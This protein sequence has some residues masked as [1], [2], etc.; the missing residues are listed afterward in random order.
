MRV[1]ARSGYSNRPWRRSSSS[2]CFERKSPDCPAAQDA[3]VRTLTRAS[4]IEMSPDDVSRAE[5]IE[6]PTARGRT[7]HAFYY[8]PRLGGHSAPADERPPLIVIGHGGPIAEPEDAEYVLTHTTGVAGFFGA[9]SM[10]RLPTEIAITENM[11]RFKKIARGA[12]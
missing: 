2:A 1:A 12:A 9:S 7:A 4:A 11:R 5:P 10:E 8:P 3:R 6:F